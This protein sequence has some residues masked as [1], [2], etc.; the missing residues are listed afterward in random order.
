M[1]FELLP[2]FTVCLIWNDTPS[3]AKLTTER[4]FGSGYQIVVWT[5]KHEESEEMLR[6]EM[7]PRLV[8]DDG[9]KET[10]TAILEIRAGTGGGEASLFAAELLEMYTNWCERHGVAMKVLSETEGPDGNGLRE[11]IARVTGE[12]SWRMLRH[13]AGVHRV[14]RVPQTEGMGRIHT[15]TVSVAV[16]PGE[17]K[18]F[19][20]VPISDLD[21]RIDTYRASGAGGQHVNKVETAVRITHIPSG[22]VIQCQDER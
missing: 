10:K 3:C 18:G 2:N 20:N 15:S 4:L 9:T 21:C 16:L 19:E 5:K 14:Q 12:N 7:I 8:P 13:E 1:R 17:V 22:I 11:G 6:T